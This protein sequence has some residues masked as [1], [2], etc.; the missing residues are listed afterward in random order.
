MTKARF[1]P[2][3][4]GV[5]KFLKSPEMEALMGDHARRVAGRAGAGYR[6][7]TWQ[8]D[9][10]VIGSVITDTFGA[11]RDNSRNNTLLRALGGGRP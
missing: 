2:D 5:Q 4:A 3:R 9:S 8:G 7:S 10:R 6:P 1:Q 11:M